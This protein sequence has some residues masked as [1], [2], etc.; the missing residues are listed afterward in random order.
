MKKWLN[1]F[2]KKGEKIYTYEDVKESLAQSYKAAN[3]NMIVNGGVCAAVNVRDW[4]T[5]K[6]KA[7]AVGCA[8]WM[9][10]NIE[11]TPFLLYLTEASDDRGVPGSLVFCVMFREETGER[12]AVNE[13]TFF[14]VAASEVLSS[15]DVTTALLSKVIETLTGLDLSQPGAVIMRLPE[16]S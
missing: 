14:P 3:D 5:E 11:G 13:S 8:P 12:L 1:K 16:R 6:E 2:A 7:V 10:V 9:A 15:F 4:F